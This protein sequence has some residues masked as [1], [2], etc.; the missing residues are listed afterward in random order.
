[1]ILSERVNPGDKNVINTITKVIGAMI[2]KL[3]KVKNLYKN[4]CRSKWLNK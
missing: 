3:N 2:T 1:M 4:I